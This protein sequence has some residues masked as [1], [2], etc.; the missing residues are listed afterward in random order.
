MTVMAEAIGRKYVTFTVPRAILG[1]VAGLCSV[2][3]RVRGRDL[4]FNRD[5]LNELLPDYWICS[6]QNAKDRFGFE[7]KYSFRDGMRETIAWYKDKKWI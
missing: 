7:F 4:P 3:G 2:I 1:G 6:N 5:K